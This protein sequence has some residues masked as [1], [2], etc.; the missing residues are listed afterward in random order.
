MNI[1]QNRADKNL[2]SNP[3][4]VLGIEA[5]AIPI[6]SEISQFQFQNWN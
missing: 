6:P 4:P 3:V 1:F 5:T 2:K